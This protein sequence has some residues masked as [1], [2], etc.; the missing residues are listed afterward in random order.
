M[1]GVPLP[2]KYIAAG[3]AVMVMCCL[4]YTAWWYVAFRPVTEESILAGRAGLLFLLTLGSGVVGVLLIGH[5]IRMVPETD[6]LT[7]KTLCLIGIVVYLTL[8][9]I[10]VWGF[11]RQATS[12]LLLIV[13]WT[14]MEA[15]SIHAVCQSGYLDGQSAVIPAAIVAVATL[16]ALVAYL[17]YYRVDVWTAFYCGMVPLLADAIAMVLMIGYV[18]SEAHKMPGS[19]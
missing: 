14:I 7:S 5:A 2:I 6:A 15:A 16:I 11:H 17:L 4:F 18:A 13:V 9:G 10:T 8:L 19:P 12:E 3:H 1:Y